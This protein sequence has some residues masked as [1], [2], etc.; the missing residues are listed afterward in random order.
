MDLVRATAHS[1]L[2]LLIAPESPLLPLNS[3]LRRAAIDLLGRGF[4]VWQPH[5]DISKVL[6]TLLELASNGLNKYNNN[7]GSEWFGASLSPAADAQRTA[8]HSLLLIASSRPQAL[9]TALNMEV[10]FL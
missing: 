6:L 10:F 7:T 9:I 5:L 1:L 8:R 4:V 2:E 3:P